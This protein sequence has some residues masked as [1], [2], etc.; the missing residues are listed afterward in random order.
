MSKF[1]SAILL[2]EGERLRL[3]VAERQ[4]DSPEPDHPDFANSC[5]AGV[6]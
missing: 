3:E 4:V 5:E 2:V 1:S 6:V